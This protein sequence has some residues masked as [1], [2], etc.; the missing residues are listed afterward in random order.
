[1]QNQ[2]QFSEAQ[3]VQN[4]FDEAMVAA[5]ALNSQKPEHISDE[6]W[7]EARNRSKTHLESAITSGQFTVEQIQRLTSV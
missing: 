7:A 5:K 3:L 2:F 1:M 4:R 6:D